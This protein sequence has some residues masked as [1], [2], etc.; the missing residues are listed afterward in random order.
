[1]IDV[2]RTTI[3]KIEAATVLTFV[4]SEDTGNGYLLSFESPHLKNKVEF[5]EEEWNSEVEFLN[6]VTNRY[7][8]A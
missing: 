8:T 7:A 5:F 6:H 1:M 4:R 3:E 2:S